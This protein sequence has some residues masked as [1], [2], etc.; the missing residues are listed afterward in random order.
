M[1][2]ISRRNFGKLCG[3]NALQNVVIVTNM[4]GQVD[5]EVGNERE[6]ELKRENDPFKLVLDKG[7][8][9]ECHENTAL[10]AERIV[11]LILGN[12]P[13]PLARS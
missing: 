11:H 13:L 8:Q 3:G 7:A 1:T 5:L 9:I 10:S 12:N 6:A 4:W 2:G